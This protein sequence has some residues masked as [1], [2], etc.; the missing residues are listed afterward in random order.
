MNEALKNAFYELIPAAKRKMFD[1]ISIDRTQHLTVV[2]ENIYQEHNASAVVRSCDCF[3]IQELHV[4][5]SENQYKV[6]R[7]I[8][9]GAG[10][11]VDMYNYHEGDTPLVDCIEKLKQNGY[12]I[13]AL[14]PD[15]DAHTIFSVPIDQPLALVFGTEWKGISDDVRAHADYTVK[16]PMV[17]F[18]ESFNVSVS[19]ALALQAL[20]HRLEN[21]DINW[22][23]S[24]TEVCELQIKW[25][26]KYMRN[27]DIVRRELEK[28]LRALSNDKKV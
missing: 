5:E 8:A 7:D 18:T 28:R 6:Q 16:I 14:T 23:L 3:G 22:K 10:R 4:I 9:R 24:P 13:A 15:A 2:L 26:Q 25:C 1:R 11:W 27:G 17:G 20:R 21:S 19:A 12:K